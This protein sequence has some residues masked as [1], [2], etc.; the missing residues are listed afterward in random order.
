MPEDGVH[1]SQ[2]LKGVLSLALM[3]LLADRESYGYELVTRLHDLALTEVQDRSVYPPPTRPHGGGRQH[4]LPPLHYGLRGAN[5]HRASLAKPGPR[6]RAHPLQTRPRKAQGG[7]AMNQ[8]ALT[9][10][11]RMRIE[12]AVKK[13]SR[14]LDGRVPRAR[15]R[16]LLTELRSNLTEAAQHVGGEQAVHQLGDLKSLSNSYLDLYRNPFDV[17]ASVC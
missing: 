9:K 8:E 14:A 11:D 15:K 6:P 10:Q 2:L 5:A 12:L 3:R 7:I 1:D 16:Q 17:H 13:I 4:G